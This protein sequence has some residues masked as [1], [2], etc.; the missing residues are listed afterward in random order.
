[1]GS[2]CICPSTCIETYRSR[3][4]IPVV[5]GLV[6]C[7]F[8]YKEIVKQDFEKKSSELGKR[9]KKLEEEKIQKKILKLISGK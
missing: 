8:A 6:Q 3:Q 4:F 7:E 1:M 2:C 9:I 5:Q